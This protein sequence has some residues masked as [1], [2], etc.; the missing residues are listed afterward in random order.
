MKRLI[1]LISLLIAG[2]V[3]AYNAK[4]DTST[5]ITFYN[6]IGMDSVRYYAGQDT[7]SW[8]INRLMVRGFSPDST[9]YVL[10]DTFD[11]PGTYF[12]KIEYWEGGAAS[13][14]YL[15]DIRDVAPAN[16]DVNIVKVGGDAIVD[17]DDGQLEVNVEK[18]KDQVP[19]DPAVSG[20]IQ[21][22][23]H[24]MQTDVI[25]ASIFADDAITND[26]IAANAIDNDQLADDLTFDSL[27]VRTFVIL[28]A[29]GNAL[30]IESGANTPYTAINIV[31]SGTS[32]DGIKFTVTGIEINAPGLIDL[33]WD[34]DTTGHKTD[35]QMGY[36][37]TQGGT[38]SLPDSVVARIDSILASV[39]WDAHYGGP[40]YLTSLQEKIGDEWLIAESNIYTWMDSIHTGVDALGAG[41]GDNA[42][43]LWLYDTGNSVMVSGIMVHAENSSGA[44]QGRNRSNVSGISVLNLNDGDYNLRIPMNSGYIQTTNPQPF[45]VSGATNDTIDV[46]WFSP[47]APAGDLC[48][49]Y[50]YVKDAND[51]GIAG[52]R[53]TATIPTNFWPITYE[54]QAIKATYATTTDGNGL[55]QLPVFPSGLLLTTDGDS[56]SFYQFTAA[57]QLFGPMGIK[58]TVPDSTTF[59][60]M[61]DDEQ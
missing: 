15:P 48:A 16:A 28:N 10:V 5:A 14:K 6:G 60:M 52:V 53:I 20:A 2:Q 4:E 56:A 42:C 31:G 41:I 24:S 22:F 19:L 32:T 50:N 25:D 59:F 35:P 44:N 7:S 17:N 55:W 27:K 43:S 39:G 47:S 21:S 57:G 58:V 51:N 46:T 30:Y 13:A 12:V 18:W 61:P 36:W 29:S 37:I 49:V 3:S 54:G 26:A 1:F 11:N 38:A 33:I 23:V 34:E 9:N 40:T 45:T 8:E